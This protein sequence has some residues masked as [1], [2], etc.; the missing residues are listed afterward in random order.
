M[1]N[2]QSL[3]RVK[4][5]GTALAFILYPICAG[6]AF[7]VHPNLMSLNISHDVQKKIAEFHGNQI[8][9]FGHFLMVIAVPLLIT[10]A[11]H[12]MNLLQTRGAW[13]GFIGGVLAI[14]GAVILAVDKG[15]LC[16]VPSAFDTLSEAEFA[17]LTPGIEAM[18]QNKGL[19]WLLWFLPLLPI[20][21][22]VQTV[23][24]VLS[25]EIPR[26]Q[27]VPMLIGS[28]LMANPDI[29][30][31]GLV[32]TIFLGIGFIPYAIQLVRNTDKVS[33]LSLAPIRGI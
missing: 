19:L 15:A 4:Q 21:F 20:G 7:A 9:H 29:D 22:I 32:A 12:F 23:G 26:W 31:I 3:A 2:N 28:I 13:W 16:L 17:S 24:L 33:N 5:M 18:F 27:S 14:G 10:I 6:I 30:I 8:L 11:I 25:N 1:S